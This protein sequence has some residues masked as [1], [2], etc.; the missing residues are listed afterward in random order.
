MM[1][2]MSVAGGS[3]PRPVPMR[4][5]DAQWAAYIE[6]A[7]SGEQQALARLYDESSHLIFSV[8]LRIVGNQADA[9]EVTL[10]VYS[11]VWKS[12]ANY[13]AERGAP[14]TWMV[15]M[16]RCRALDR[17]RSRD[18]RSRR[19]TTLEEVAEARSSGAPPEQTA[20]ENQQRTRIRE[21]MQDLLP[22]QREA[23]EMSFFLGLTHTELAERLGQPLGT[24][25]T[26]IRLGMIKLRH[27]LGAGKEL[28]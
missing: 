22:E 5:S 23:I 21:A 25:K 6:R 26:R 13:S 4:P 8:V 3:G 19:E 28:Q 14:S 9:E 10:D 2:M 18:A 7:A 12:A 27:A 24:V 15:M 1:L 16:A 17:L 20:W 11:Q